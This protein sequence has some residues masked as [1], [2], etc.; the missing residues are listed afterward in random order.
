MPENND[1]VAAPPEPPVG[2]LCAADLP[3]LACQVESLRAAL[4][5]VLDTREKEANAYFAW[6]TA[7][8]NYASG[9]VR[10]DRQ[11]MA[12]MRAASN[13]EQEARLLL[14]TMKTPNA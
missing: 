12:A 6:N 13:A 4:V 11:H 5:K 3:V 8:Q 10:E 1:A 14:A 2:R 9:A 7:I